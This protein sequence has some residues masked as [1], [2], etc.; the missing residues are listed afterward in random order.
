MTRIL[1]LSDSGVPSGYGRIHDSL[2]PRIMKRGY[3]VQAASIMYDG[4]L[5]PHY[6]AQRLPYFVSSLAGRAN[7][8]EQFVAV[9]NAY[10][11]DIILVIQDAP[12]AEVVKNA[13]LDWSRYALMVI[14]PVDGAPVLPS[15]VQML[16]SADGVMSISQFGVDTHRAAGVASELC[17]PGIDPD[18]FFPL[19]DQHRAAIRVKLGIAPDA[20]VFGTVAQNQGRKDIPH[21][22]EAFFRFAADKPDARYLMNMEPQSPAGWDLH[23]LCQQQGWDAGKII[24]RRDCEQ[25]GVL[26]LRDRYNIMDAHAVIAHREGF[27]L[28]LVEAQACGVVSMALGYSSGTEICG[29]GHGVL[30]KPI[31]YTTYSTWGGALDKHPD[32]S[33]FVAQLERLHKYPDERRAIAVKGMERARTWTWDR[34]V[35]NTVNVIERI[36]S[37]RRQVPPPNQPLVMPQPIPQSVDGMQP[38]EQVALVEQA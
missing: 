15:W 2:L 20:F 24:W 23:Q 17:R 19:T 22:M 25:R 3:Q 33:D 34:S 8:V 21:M 7:W 37:A 29:A 11:P 10:Q 6:E 16:K 26:E 12:Y 38:I 32:M 13:P 14:T 1:T 18:T 5:P 28:P 4:L 36:M 27:G 30:V 31:E 35:D 9:V